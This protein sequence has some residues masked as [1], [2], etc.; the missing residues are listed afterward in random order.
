MPVSPFARLR[1]ERDVLIMDQRGTGRSNRLDCQF[2]DDD[3][4]DPD[5]VDIAAITRTCRDDLSQRAALTQY[6]TSVAVRDLE[7]LRLALGYAQLNLYGVSYGTRVAQHYA[8]RYADAT[9]TLILDGVVPP[10]LVLGPEMALDAE[11]ALQ[12]ILARCQND[13][14]C[15]DALGNPL[16]DYRALW[17]ALGEQRVKVTLADPRTG[18]QR[19]LEFG[20]PHLSAVLR[21][22]SYDPSQSALL[23]MALKQAQRD[24]DFRALAAQYLMIS[25]SLDSTVAYGMHN[26][27]ACSEDAP[28]IDLATLPR[29]ALA[30][31]HMGLKQV[32]QLVA[33]CREW[34]RGIVDADLHA[35]LSS[36]VPA[37]LMSGGND[38]VTPPK[39]ATEAQRAFTDNAHLV[40]PGFGHGQLMAPGVDT[41]MAQFVV[42]GTAAKL[43]TSCTAKLK[44]MPFFLSPAGPAP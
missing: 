39:Y 21:L 14:E 3:L 25:R 31:T 27:V 40:L 33:M 38:P 12:R 11:A 5:S 4:I 7:T 32:E 8:R 6:T 37:L 26:S 16:V 44:P 23:P 29:D 20:Q 13:P 9:R 1:R 42:A 36:K 15:H 17:A 19:E 28:L 41:I 2:D 22:A 34:P 35:P 30:A 43:N 10:T 18:V 24:R